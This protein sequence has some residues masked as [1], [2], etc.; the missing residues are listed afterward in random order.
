MNILILGF[1]KIKYMPYINFYLDNIDK[2]NN[3]EVVYWNRDTLQEDLSKYQ[4]ISFHEFCLYQVLYN[5][6]IS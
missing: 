5:I 3:I 6:G 1:T 4:G 2:S